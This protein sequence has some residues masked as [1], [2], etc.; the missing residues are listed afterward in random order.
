MAPTQLQK[1]AV[2]AETQ[3]KCVSQRAKPSGIRK[4]RKVVVKPDI[5]KAFREL[6]SQ[7]YNDLFTP[8]RPTVTA[9]QDVPDTVQAPN[10]IPVV[11]AKSRPN[12]VNADRNDS[13]KGSLA[14]IYLEL[15]LASVT[16]EVPL[17][18]QLDM[19]EGLDYAPSTTTGFRLSSEAVAMLDALDSAAAFHDVDVEPADYTNTAGTISNNDNAMKLSQL[20]CIKVRTSQRYGA[21]ATSHGWIMLSILA[22]CATFRHCCHS[23]DLK[24]WYLLSTAIGNN[25]TSIEI[26]A[27][28]RDLDWKSALT[29][30]ARRRPSTLSLDLYELLQTSIQL[31]P[32]S[33][34]SYVVSD[35]RVRPKHPTIEG[36]EQIDINDS[37]YLPEHF[38]NAPIQKHWPYG[39]PHPSNPTTR[40][41]SDGICRSCFSSSWCNCSPN[42]CALVTRPLVELKDYGTKGVGIR[43]LQRIA[44]D[45]VLGEYVGL[46]LPA[47]DKSDHVY[48]FD[49][50]RADAA[51]GEEAIA[52]ICAKNYG[53][54]TRFINHS[55]KASAYFSA[56][57][58]G[59][60]HRVMIVAER[61]IEAFEE[62]TVDYGMDYWRSRQC[63]CGEEGCCNPGEQ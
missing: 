21:F 42:N 14:Q 11:E 50:T 38:T 40:T 55:C 24:A 56:K 30:I 16:R 6:Q 4:V 27:K 57:I 58:I 39:K 23:L 36:R 63:F 48:S 46:L 49:F 7:Y 35:K 47:N 17:S 18:S 41:F 10:Q 44:K 51:S 34:H 43:T 45:D 3:R 22:N 9:S 25:A 31:K 19:Y 12:V 60:K 33:P 59:Q 32:G 26:F 29:Y 37:V 28:V 15:H 8:T 61:D 1:R 53:N 54:W 5:S 13:T 2:R 62:L 20:A 52:T